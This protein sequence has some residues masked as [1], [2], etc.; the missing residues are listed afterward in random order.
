METQDLGDFAWSIDDRSICVWEAPHMPVRS[1]LFLPS[2]RWFCFIQQRSSFAWQY[3]VVLYPLGK[4]SGVDQQRKSLSAYKD[5]LSVK[6]VA[7]FGFLL[8]GVWFSPS[9]TSSDPQV[10]RHSVH[11][12]G[13]LR[14]N[15]P[16]AEFAYVEGG[17]GVQT[18]KVIHASQGYGTL[19]AHV[20]VKAV[21]A[22]ADPSELPSANQTIYREMETWCDGNDRH[23]PAPKEEQRDSRYAICTFPFIDL[24]SATLAVKCS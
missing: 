10:A 6:T 22:R 4:T 15:G 2:W 7:W 8:R 24:L 3:K 18:L 14:P 23:A 16:S 5:Q 12:G 21:A 13:Q 17:D 9:H 1:S 20:C 11:R 19:S